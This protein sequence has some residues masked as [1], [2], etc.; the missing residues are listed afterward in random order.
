MKLRLMGCIAGLLVTGIASATP[1]IWEAYRNHYGFG[2]ESDAFKANCLNCHTAPPEHNAFGKLIKHTMM[3]QGTP[4]QLTPAVFKLVEGED[5]D[6][7]G[8]TNGEEAQ[9]GFNAGD[10]K[11]RPAGSPPKAA[12]MPPQAMS[13]SPFM[14]RHTFHPVIVHFP[15]ALFIFG[16]FLEFLGRY[17]KDDVV[18]GVAFWNL[19]FGTIATLVAIPTGFIAALRLGYPLAVGTPVFLHLSLGI[20]AA[21][22]MLGVVL[23]RRTNLVTHKAYWMLLALAAAAVGIAGHFGGQMVYG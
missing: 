10:P 17:R 3:G 7:D 14:P 15:I 4:K 22:L 11:S 12:A 18:R 23:W 8:W 2:A 16:A 1:E 9:Q 5:S 13:E 19:L 6:G 21:L 20:S